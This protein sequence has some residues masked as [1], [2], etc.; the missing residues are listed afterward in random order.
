MYKTPLYV[1]E[2]AKKTLRLAIHNDSLF[3]AN[4][5]VM[6]Y[7]L[8]W[9]GGDGATGSVADC[10]IS[11]IDSARGELVV[12]II[13]FIRTFTLDK[14]FESWVVR[15]ILIL[16]MVADRAARL[17]RLRSTSLSRADTATEEHRQGRAHHHLAHFMCVTA[18]IQTTCR[19][20]AR[21]ARSARTL[22]ATCTDPAQIA[23][24][25]SP[26]S[27]RTSS[28]ARTPGLGRDDRRDLLCYSRVD[29]VS[30]SRSL[31]LV[32]CMY[33]MVVTN[34]SAAMSDRQC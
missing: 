8:V 3:L 11:A 6:D 25:S 13:D 31:Y 29:L 24:A 9:C 16:V 34:G 2:Q 18:G 14:R 20:S 26:L 1:T 4:L 28:S 22:L 33:D 19:P 27:S 15:S 23:T 5:Q 17:V 12:G 10:M 32:V 7:S 30:S 21:C